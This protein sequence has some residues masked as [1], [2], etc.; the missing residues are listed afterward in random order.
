MSQFGLTFLNSR[1]RALCSGFEFASNFFGGPVRHRFSVFDPVRW[2][3]E[4]ARFLVAAGILMAV[5]LSQATPSRAQACIGF[6]VQTNQTCINSTTLTN[7]STAAG[8]NAG[9]QDAGTLTVTNTATGSINGNTGIGFASFGIY[10]TGDANVTNAG[11]IDGTTSS[12]SSANGIFVFDNANVTN[13]GTI[14]AIAASY[15]GIR[16]RHFCK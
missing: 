8:G 1:L 14:Y 4:D 6:P 7:T 10:S 12:A 11:T 2:F 9:L 3:E 5:M 13:S 15:S 16:N